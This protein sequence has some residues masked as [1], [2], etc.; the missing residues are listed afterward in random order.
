M[1]TLS[2][3]VILMA[4]SGSRLRVQHKDFLKPLIPVR[5]R[6]LISYTIDALVRSGI[7]SIT[8]IV[9]Y[10][11]DVVMNAV[12]KLV[13]AHVQLRFV[14]NREWQKQN[15]ISLLTAAGMLHTP[16]FLTMSDH[17]F[18]AAIVDLIRQHGKREL[19]NI[20]IDRKLSA[21]FDLA[22]A[23]KIKTRA[24][25]LTTIGKDLNDFDSIDTGVFV[26]PPEIFSY[27]ER[28]K[29]NG[30]CSLTDAVR[31][32]AQDGKVRCIDIGAA[33]WQD[34]DTPEMLRHAERM[35]ER[36]QTNARTT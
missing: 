1:K 18:D 8:A 36:A 35:I 22:D 24:T 6:P 25:G 34:V 7:R 14:V 2:D 21:I 16:F 9:G 26:C 27:L 10:E 5:G 33:W 29:K 11:S 32:M 23:T 30:D 15:G 20:A 19:L 31:L 12:T 17:I 28:A 4:G 13:P 3:A